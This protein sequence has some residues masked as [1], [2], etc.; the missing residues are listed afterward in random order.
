MMFLTLTLHLR[1]N[2]GYSFVIDTLASFVNQFLWLRAQMVREIYH[3][4]VVGNIS[5]LLQLSHLI[6]AYDQTAKSWINKVIRWAVLRL[7]FCFLILLIW[8][9]LLL[10]TPSSPCFCVA[11][12]KQSGLFT[13]CCLYYPSRGKYTVKVLVDGNP[14][15]HGYLHIISYHTHTIIK[16]YSMHTTNH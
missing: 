14:C 12:F 10:C 16:L 1:C 6:R 2:S 15:T 9:L 7:F 11:C 8:F 5:F 4:I 3:S 13:H